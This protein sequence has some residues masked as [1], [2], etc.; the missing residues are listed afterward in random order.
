[1]KSA[2]KA[3]SAIVIET[4]IWRVVSGSSSSPTAFWADH[5]R[6]RNPRVRDSPKTMMPRM[7]GM[8]ANRDREDNLGRSCVTA[9]IT[10]SGLAHRH[11]PGGRGAHHHSFDDRLAADAGI[12]GATHRLLLG[13]LGPVRRRSWSQR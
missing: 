10:P 11:R 12:G 5:E 9:S 1:M 3:T 4:A 6:D 13:I 7:K 8:R 2:A